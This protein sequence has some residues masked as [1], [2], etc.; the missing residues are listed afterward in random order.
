MI[1][2][3]PAFASRNKT[4]MA[5]GGSI[6]APRLGYVR[7]DQTVEDLEGCP[8]YPAPIPALLSAVRR[9]I[10]KYR[11]AP[12]SIQKD[13]GE[14]KHVI[15][16]ASEA[17]GEALVRLVLRSRAE[18][19][20]AEALLQALQDQFP[21]VVVTS[22]NFQPVRTAIIEGEEELVLSERS[23]IVE[24]Y[25]RYRFPLSPQ[26]FSQV[27][28]GVAVQ[29]YQAAAKVV[30]QR[31][32]KTVLDL[33]CGVGAFS[34][35]ASPY[36]E[37]VLGVE[38][39]SQAIS[40]AIEATRM[41]QISN[42]TFLAADVGT[43]LQ[44]LKTPYEA[45]I[46]NPP[47]RGL[48]PEICKQLMPNVGELLLYSSCNSETLAKDLRELSAQFSV[49]E[50]TPFDMFPNTPHMEVLVELHRK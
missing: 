36:V 19:S 10:T 49:R 14:L 13:K 47:R 46:V 34:L 18:L 7:Q 33:F 32:P 38:L 11:L 9:G 42:A 41:N 8:L 37:K 30:A 23:T 15:I 5:V 29:L 39:S 45:V 20:R 2:A 24:Q 6:E 21:A 28:S 31:R 44:Q 17:S 50:V 25:D 26:S 48:G 27:T 43:F 12:Y 35:F 3:S 22:V 4:K 40:N 1:T 16:R